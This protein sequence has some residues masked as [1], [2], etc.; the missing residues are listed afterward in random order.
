MDIGVFSRRVDTSS[1]TLS[2]TAT[3]GVRVGNTGHLASLGGTYINSTLTLDDGAQASIST[4]GRVTAPLAFGGTN[5][6]LVFGRLSSRHEIDAMRANGI[7]VNHII[8]P[9]LALAWACPAGLLH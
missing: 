2:G 6:V 1:L 7:N 8:V 4:G 5:S 9:P 3:G